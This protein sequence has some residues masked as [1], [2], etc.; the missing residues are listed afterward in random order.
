M[1]K[2]TS[3]PAIDPLPKSLRLIFQQR[4]YATLKEFDAATGIGYARVLKRVQSG[5]IPAVNIGQSK[6]VYRI[7]EG[8]I[9]DWFASRQVKPIAKPESGPAD[10]PNFYDADGNWI[11]PSKRGTKK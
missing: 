7:Y 4:D 1:S 2:A 11:P 5:D 8:P 10:A 6:A 3:A 9:R